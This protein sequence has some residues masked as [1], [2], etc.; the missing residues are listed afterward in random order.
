[1]SGTRIIWRDTIEAARRELRAAP[2]ATPLT[3]AHYDPGSLVTLDAMLSARGA[4]PFEGGTF[5][6]PEADGST[7]VHDFQRGDVICFA[8]V[9][10]RPPRDGR[11]E[12]GARD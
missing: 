4:F 2:T 1:M 12:G 9:P 10:P 7:T 6:T 5:T 3:A 8:Q 11:P